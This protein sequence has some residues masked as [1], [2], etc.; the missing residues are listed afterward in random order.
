MT[1]LLRATLSAPIKKSIVDLV[2]EKTMGVML[3]LAS[4]DEKNVISCALA[5]GLVAT[6]GIGEWKSKRKAM[7]AVFERMHLG[8]KAEGEYLERARELL[9]TREQLGHV[10]EG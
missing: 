3:E 9:E 7:L 2:E 6:D 1:P 5:I 10:I 8:P 4:E